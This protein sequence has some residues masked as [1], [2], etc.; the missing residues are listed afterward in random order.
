MGGG[1]VAARSR[2]RLVLPIVIGVLFGLLVTQSIARAAPANKVEIC[3]FNAD[4][5]PDAPVWE[6]LEVNNKAVSKHRA[7]GDGVPGGPVPGDDA[8]IFGPQCELVPVLD[9][10]VMSQNLYIGADLDR[11]LQGEPPAAVLQTVLAT[12]YPGRAA[13][14]A[15]TIGA[16]RPD[17]VGLQEATR[18]TVFDSQGNV[19]LALDYLEILMG[20]LNAQGHPYGVSSAVINADVTLP[21]DTASGIFARVI[22]RDAII[23]NTE[24]TTVANAVSQNF[25]TNFAIDLGG[26][27]IEFTRGFTGVD[28]TVDGQTFR[29]V[30]TH[31][32]VRNA[33]CVTPVGVMVCQN[34]QAGE[35]IDALAGTVSPTIL[36]G[37]FNAALGETAYQTV[38]DGG[39]T[40]TWNSQTEAGNT[41]CQF[42]LLDNAESELNQ[43]IDHLFVRDAEIVSATTTVL[44]DEQESRTAG[45]L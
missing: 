30:N 8:F 24:T 13:K 15:E 5:D 34:A 42:E 36:V 20:Q 28:A 21:I 10:D 22:D 19:L 2:R 43:R 35:L 26:V 25:A 41:C 12:D 17:L 9:V 14:I 23:H 31:L 27:P 40:D 3:H 18:I 6:L 4:G 32:E 39:F 37:D 44:G 7:H 29:F 38:G 1:H 11:I 16:N 33:P 45:G